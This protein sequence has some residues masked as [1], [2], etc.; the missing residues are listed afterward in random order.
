M[1]DYTSGKLCYKPLK[2]SIECP[3]TCKPINY[4]TQEKKKKNKKI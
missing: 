3:D 4:D 2:Q 1:L